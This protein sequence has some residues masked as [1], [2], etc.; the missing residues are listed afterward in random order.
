MGLLDLFIAP[1]KGLFSLTNS[2]VKEL[3]NVRL[4]N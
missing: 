1:I 2:Y 4:K 3:K